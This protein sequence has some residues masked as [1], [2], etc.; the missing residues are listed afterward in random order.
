MI[1]TIL[2]PIVA[3]TFGL[4][5]Y[6]YEYEDDIYYNPKKSSTTATN[7]RSHAKGS[8]HLVD[9]SSIDID[10]YNRRGNYFYT[11]ID[12]IGT[13]MENEPDFVYTTQIQKFYNPTIVTDNASVIQDIL[14]NSYGNVEIVFNYNGSPSFV[15]WTY[16]NYPY[17]AYNF[18]GWGGCIGPFSIGWNSWWNWGPSWNWAWTGWG[19]AWIPGWGPTWTPGPGFYANY[20]PGGRRPFANMAYNHR[21]GNFQRSNLASRVPSRGTMAGR[22]FMHTPTINHGNNVKPSTHPNHSITAGGRSQ[23][24]QLGHSAGDFNT[25]NKS[26]RPATEI[27]GRPTTGIVTSRPSP[28]VTHKQPSNQVTTK[29]ASTSQPSSPRKPSGTVNSQ[30][31]SRPSNNSTNRSNM[32]GSR[33]G[34]SFGGSHGG[35]FGGG[36]RSSGGRR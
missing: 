17:W 27:V 20:R 35:S 14:N 26:K 12:T 36:G 34:G 32:G 7:A 3:L 24:S 1:K 5:A 4:S 6:A 25:G 18:W 16:Y 22:G 19:P 29:P 11:D 33:N 30:P 10:E 9:F 15:P 31:S 28:A 2:L 23:R 13:F 8:S 21:A